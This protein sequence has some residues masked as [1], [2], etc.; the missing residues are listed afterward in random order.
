[1]V[2]YDQLTTKIPTHLSNMTIGTGQIDDLDDQGNREEKLHQVDGPIDIH[3]P[4][5]DSDENKNGEQG[6]NTQ[7]RPRQQYAPADTVRKEMTEQRQVDI[8]KQKEKREKAKS[9]TNN[10]KDIPN[11]I[12][13]P[14]PQKSKGKATHPDQIKSSKKGRKQPRKDN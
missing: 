1:M 14:K 4:T 3:T 2:Q 12:N 6:N 9:Q 11:I 13:R 8:L 10:N 5:D 7:K